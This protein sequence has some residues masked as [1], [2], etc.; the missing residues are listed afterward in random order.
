MRSGRM[1]FSMKL[2]R[3]L[4]IF[5]TLVAS[6]TR[7]RSVSGVDVTVDAAGEQ[8]AESEPSS[9]KQLLRTI[10]D[11]ALIKEIKRRGYK[12]KRAKKRTTKSSVVK[13]E[14]NSI[15]STG[16]KSECHKPSTERRP[17]GRNT[18]IQTVSR[19]GT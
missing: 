10:S 7:D 14:P 19:Y 6:I 1:A 13:H 2:R 16:A 17:V 18:E 4:I 11:K 5:A 15:Q 12:V 9:V 8:V 3:A